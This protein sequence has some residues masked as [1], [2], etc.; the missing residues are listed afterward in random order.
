MQVH[1]R[2]CTSTTKNMCTQCLDLSNIPL[3][4]T[5]THAHTHT[6]FT[7]D[8]ACTAAM[9]SLSAEGAAPLGTLVTR[10]L[11]AERLPSSSAFSSELGGPCKHTTSTHTYMVTHN[12]TLPLGQSACPPHLPSPLSWGLPAS[13]PHVH[14]HTHTQ[15]A[16]HAYKHIR[17]AIA[18]I[19]K[20]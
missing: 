6:P 15:T 9:A 19:V 8:S 14:T 11:L 20:T 13:T 12:Y 5:H 10:C 18:C 4:H 17:T 7:L 2:L 1:T 16:T 3:M